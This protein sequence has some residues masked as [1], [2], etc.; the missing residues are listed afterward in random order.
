MSTKAL[1]I[2]N[3]KTGTIVFFMADLEGNFPLVVSEIDEC[4]DYEK[5][6]VSVSYQNKSGQIKTDVLPLAI[7]RQ[8]NGL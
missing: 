4:V 2:E 8:A 1:K 3:L 6:E 7:L 5:P